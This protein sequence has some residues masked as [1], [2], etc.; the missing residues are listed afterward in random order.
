[1]ANTS[2]AIGFSPVRNLAGASWNQQTNIY[3]IPSTDGSAY[4]LGDVVKSA[5]NADA[6]GVPAVQKAA[7]TDTVRGVIVGVSPTLYNPVSLQGTA[8]ALEQVSIPATK[9]HDYYVYVVDDPDALFECQDDGGGS[10]TVATIKTYANKNC[11]FTVATPAT[12]TAP[13]SASVLNFTTAPTTT[14]SLNVKLMGLVQRPGNTVAVGA[15]WIVKFNQHELMG[16]TTA[17]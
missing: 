16:G 13:I 7:G 12:A 3:V 4:Y 6:N 15:R 5:A 8:L 1:M 10:A 14:S 9:T 17:I 2:A 11:T